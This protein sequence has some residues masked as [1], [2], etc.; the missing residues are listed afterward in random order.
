[1]GRLECGRGSPLSLA[2][3]AQHSFRSQPRHPQLAVRGTACSLVRVR[4]ELC[5]SRS[6]RVGPSRRSCSRA[7]GPRH[8]SVPAAPPPSHTR[9]DGGLQRRRHVDA[10]GG[11]ARE[12]HQRGDVGRPLHRAGHRQG[13]RQQGALREGR[14]LHALPAARPVPAAQGARHGETGRQAAPGRRRA[15]RALLARKGD[16]RSGARGVA[17]ER[18]RRRARSRVRNALAGSRY[19]GAFPRRTSADTST[20]RSPARRLP[21]PLPRARPAELAAAPRCGLRV[22]QDRRQGQLAAGGDLPRARREGAV[23]DAVRWRSTAA[24]ERLEPGSPLC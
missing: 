11:R 5:A 24:Q 2:W 8:T 14:H 13:R 17:C 4:R 3:R 15:A 1:M 10:D 12:L 7:V 22:A 19:G 18:A 21:S 6:R 16:G 9:E 23:D 20:S